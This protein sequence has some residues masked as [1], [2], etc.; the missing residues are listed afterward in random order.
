MANIYLRV[1]TYLAQW[2][3]GRVAPEPSLTEFEPVV[4]S[5]FQEEYQMMSSWLIHVNEHDMENTVCFSERMWK[6]M[7]NGRSPRGGRKTVIKRQPTEW[8]SMAE[9]TFLSGIA[10]TKKTESYDYLCI[11]APKYVLI[12]NSWKVV[13]PSF[14]MN[15][16]QAGELVRQLSNEFKR[17]LLHWVTQELFLCEKR[18]IRRDATMCVDHFFY[19]Y[20]VCLGTNKPDRD[21]MRRMTARWMEEAKMMPSDIDDEDALFLYENERKN[22]R[23][24]IDAIIKDV[25]SGI[26]KH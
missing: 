5:K 6:N 2:Y 19:H 20:N 17:M 9:V 11:Q 23:L 26:K 1:P 10:K 15:C 3:R 24:D 14:T 16:R 25:N 21:S 22:S 8:L 12:G 7:L 4:F 13:T 18:G